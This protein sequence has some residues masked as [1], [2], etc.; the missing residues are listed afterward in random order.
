MSHV[1]YTPPNLLID[2]NKLCVFKLF[3]YTFILFLGH[4]PT[5]VVRKC[6]KRKFITGIPFFSNVDY[7]LAQ[8][9]FH[10]GDKHDLGTEHAINGKRFSAE[11]C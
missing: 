3:F 6:D 2:V 8:W 11:V 7:Q 4:A 5:F 9:H 10:F 1:F